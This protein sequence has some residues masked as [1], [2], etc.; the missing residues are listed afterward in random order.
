MKKSV[1]LVLN[2]LFVLASLSV[3]AHG[4][5][6]LEFNPDTAQSL[7]VADVAAPSQVFFAQNDFLG[8]FDLWLANPGSSGT[9]TFQL[10]N[11]QGSVIT[12]KTVTIPYIAQT[13][14]GTQFHVD[15]SSQVAVLADNKY[16]IKIIS[17][18]PEL[19]LYY[20]NRVQ[21]ISHNAPFVSPYI[22]GVGKLGSEEQTFSFKY[23]LYETTESSAPIISNVSW[24]VV[25][26]TQMRVDFNANEPVD[27]RVEYGPSGQGYTQSTNF[28]G[29]YQ[30]C[31]AGIAFC[32]VT[33][34]VS[35][36]TTYQYLLTVKDSWGNQSQSSGTFTSGQGQTPTP[37]PTP[38][39]T[40]TPTATPVP[41][42]TTTVPSPS[43]LPDT[44]PPVISNFR[45]ASLT[46][47]SVGIAWTTNEAANSYLLISTTFLTTVTDVSDPTLELEH[48]LSTGNVLGPSTTYIAKITSIDN[49][50]NE[51]K[52]SMSFTTNAF[53][54]ES[55]PQTSPG[56]PPPSQ[57]SS[58]S[59][60]T[61]SSNQGSGSIQWKPSVGTEPS[62]GYR[63]D[64]FDKNGNLVKTIFVP[65][66]SRGV[67]IPDLAEGEYSVIVYADNDG[68]FQ[69][70]DQ[71]AQLKI[72]PPFIKKLLSF[73]P[74]LL[75][76]LGLAG[77]LVWRNLKKK[78]LVSNFPP[79][80]S[81]N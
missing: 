45:V 7:K 22:T 30:F 52:A 60:V 21:V 78:T 8:G 81:S 42:G 77:F 76:A 69:K 26:P 56:P 41:T 9:A 71:P 10:L 16:S 20:S 70:I 62:G 25:S 37:T 75:V 43:G 51:S 49:S 33:I 17:S 29:G 53:V 2:A 13:S 15:F 58:Q 14:N 54:P 67:E 1:I 74:Y 35:S 38:T 3:S 57:Q 72:E 80:S 50:S 31:A 79:S 39:P 4:T 34:S 63:I 27:F 12:S 66:G 6:Y 47:K 68:V 44:T 59:Q 19:R 11:E 73:W 24:T 55:S 32:S 5:N 46:D 64:V 36:G 48:F 61:A 65:G 23:A 28:T 18:M 40:G